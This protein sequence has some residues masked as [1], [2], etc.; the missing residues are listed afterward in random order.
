MQQPYL[1]VLEDAQM[2][3]WAKQGSNLR[4][5]GCDPNALP[6]ELFALI[7]SGLSTADASILTTCLRWVKHRTVRSPTCRPGSPLHAYG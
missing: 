6:A 2:D 4:P 5:F 7:S 1:H 3:Y